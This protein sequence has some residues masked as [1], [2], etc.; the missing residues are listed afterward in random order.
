MYFRDALIGRPG[1][2]V[3]DAHVS[4]AGN[5]DYLVLRNV[6]WRS[7]TDS[8]YFTTKFYQVSVNVQ[9]E[10]TEKLQADFLY[11]KSSSNNS[12]QGLLVEFNRM[13]SPESFVYDERAHGSMP[14]LW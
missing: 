12:N 10:I 9:Q 7:A 5:A 11:G 2:D 8:S 14:A 1:V 13:D 6:D 3:L 4:A